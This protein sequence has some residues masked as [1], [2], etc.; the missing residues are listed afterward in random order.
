MKNLITQTAIKQRILKS[1][2]E[3]QVQRAIVDYLTARRIPHSITD[4]TQTFNKHGQQVRR[5]KTGWP[6][7]T[8]CYAGHFLAIEVK[9]PIGGRLSRE[10]AVTLE[11]LW[12][13]GALILIARSVD[14]LM[15]LLEAKKTPQSTL[16]E[17]QKA[18]RLTPRP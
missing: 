14:D 15:A 13:Q 7:I 18:L 1:V 6:D 10:Q 4:A 16:D 2:G 3:S 17:I 9:R 5:V 11:S 12:R 8:A